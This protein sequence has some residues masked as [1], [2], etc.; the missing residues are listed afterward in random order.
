[1]K[2][3]RLQTLLAAALW[4]ALVSGQA[5]ATNTAESRLEMTYTLD[6]VLINGTTPATFETSLEV[7]D[8]VFEDFGPNGSEF[9]GESNS[10]PPASVGSATT[11][12]AYS[13]NGLDPFIDDYDMDS[14]GIGD[15]LVVTMDVFASATT[16]GSLFF[17]QV[18]DESTLFFNH[19]LD[20]TDFLTF[21][22]SWQAHLTAT[23]DNTASPGSALTLADGV[24]VSADVESPDSGP[25]YSFDVAT[26]FFQILESNPPS[27]L[28]TP[29]V[30][31]SGTFE[32]TFAPGDNALAINFLTG[33]TA[34]ASVEV[35]EPGSLALIALGGLCVLRR[36]R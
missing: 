33:I 27:T 11:S 36:R 14:F 24:L 18:S 23:L 22:F 16:P 21:Q 35:P 9:T 4:S 32:V 19:F 13:L 30:I 31:E 26:D 15:S 7:G 25:A 1:M 29:D 34:N 12:L 17:A 8:L 20:S 28:D 10:N 5:Y 3:Q 2:K 6:N